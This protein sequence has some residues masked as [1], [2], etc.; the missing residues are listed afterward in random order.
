MSVGLKVDAD[1]KASCSMM[2]VLHSS[3][4]THDRELQIL[5]DVV[6]TRTIG[7]SG[8]YDTNLEAIGKT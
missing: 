3:R 2:Q 6:S 5:S 7:I 8:L 1:V 4:S